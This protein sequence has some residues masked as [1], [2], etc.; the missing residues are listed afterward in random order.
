[1]TIRTQ[2]LSLRLAFASRTHRWLYFGCGTWWER[3]K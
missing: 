3:V 1:M 2:R